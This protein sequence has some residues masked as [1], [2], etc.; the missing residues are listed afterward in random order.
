M[1]GVDKDKGGKAGTKVEPCGTPVYKI[2]SINLR[3][4]Q[5]TFDAIEN[6]LY[7]HTST[8]FFYIIFQ[9]ST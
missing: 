8:T 2:Y 9:Q 5:S 1:I 3:V 7:I 4:S 6:T